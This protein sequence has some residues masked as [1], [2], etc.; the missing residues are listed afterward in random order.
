MARVTLTEV[1]AW[2]ESSKLPITSLDA[3]LLAHLEEEVITQLA[4]VYDTSGWTSN[5]NTPKLVRTA[6]SK[7]YASWYIDKAYS[8]NQDEGNDYAQRLQ[9]NADMLI[10]AL[11]GGQVVIPEVPAPSNPRTPS[12]YPNDASS[13]LEPTAEDPSLGGPY[14]SL[15]RTF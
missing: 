8:E 13:A 15:G 3:E 2:L 10:A 7:Y 6:I 1:Q 9:E 11:V 12:Y 4:T 5:L 14:F